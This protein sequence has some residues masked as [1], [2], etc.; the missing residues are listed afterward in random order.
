MLRSGLYP[1]SSGLNIRLADNATI[2]I[3]L[4]A[5]VGCK[6]VQAGANRIESESCEPGL[7]T[8]CLYWSACRA[9][10]LIVKSR[11]GALAGLALG[12]APDPSSLVQRLSLYLIVGHRGRV[13]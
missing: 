9:F 6:I 4:L 3:V 1:T 2:F 12:N 10:E 8:R 5:N 11:G 13:I 7:N